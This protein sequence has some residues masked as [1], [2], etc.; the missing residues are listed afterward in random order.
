MTE[1]GTVA[2]PSPLLVH[3]WH[4]PRHFA[5][6]ATLFPILL[7]WIVGEFQNVPALLCALGAGFFL[8]S[9]LHALN[10]LSD[11]ISGVDKEGGS[12]EKLY[13]AGSQVLVRGW[14]SPW[15]VAANVAVGL[16]LGI[17]LALVMVEL[18]GTLWPLFGLLVGIV[19]GGTYSPVWKYWLHF[20]EGI[21][22]FAMGFAGVAMGMATSG[23]VDIPRAFL[24]GIA[25]S[26]PFAVGW[27]I[28]QAAD[29]ASDIERGVHNIGG[30]LYVTGFPLWAY[31]GLGILA[32]YTYIVFLIVIGVL[33]PWAGLVF[34]TWPLWVLCLAWLAPF[35]L[36]RAV[37]WGLLAIFLHMLLLV[38]AES[39]ERIR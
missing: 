1:T 15:A 31:T 39:L 27:G 2:R 24:I 33:S 30:L 37:R 35:S 11:Y 32:S 9:S 28:D 10:T 14:A 4:L 38:V 7:G 21:G 8:S 19:V 3:A 34:L 5:L 17:L 20:P 6:L 23:S 12:V 36:N 16:I 26:L 29:A 22:L 13:S 25:I 18:V